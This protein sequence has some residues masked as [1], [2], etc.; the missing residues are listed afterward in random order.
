MN[1]SFLNIRRNISRMKIKRT[2]ALALALLTL[3]VFAACNVAGSLYSEKNAYVSV[4]VYGENGKTLLS[5][6]AIRVAP[7]EDDG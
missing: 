2:I 1:Y 6:D 7:L 4:Y 3:L 5:T